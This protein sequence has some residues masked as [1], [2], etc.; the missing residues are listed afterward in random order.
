MSILRPFLSSLLSV[1]I[2]VGTVSVSTTATASGSISLGSVGSMAMHVAEDS[3]AVLTLDG[4]DAASAEKLSEALR[5]AFAKRGL[6]GSHELSLVELRLTMGCDND[7]PSCLAQGG[8]T[9]G[10]RRIVYGYL[11]SSGSGYQ[12]DVRILEV[13]A[14][15]IDRNAEISITKADLAPNKIDDTATRIVNNLLP[16][17]DT[18]ALPPRVSTPAEYTE[19]GEPIDE[20]QKPPRERNVWVGLEKPTPGWKWAGFG[21]SLG[22]AVA[23]GVTL[24]VLASELNKS[25]QALQDAADESLTDG[26]PANDID[27]SVTPDLCAAATANTPTEDAPNAV[28]N[29]KMT[30]ICNRGSGLSAGTYAA[31]AGLA[32]FGVSTLIFTGLLFIHRNKP[33][34]LAMKRRGVTFGAGPTMDGGVSVAGSM[35]F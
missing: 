15:T 23:S 34:A 11:R 1:S 18:D 35:K 17:E 26:N 2:A 13:D 20:V 32:V 24:A 31:G 6:S 33:G 25:E 4:D 28:R 16:G 30:R 8:K 12:V 22:L 5:R 29:A 3:A 10:V 7:E 9:L 19:P 21:V 14:S 27:R